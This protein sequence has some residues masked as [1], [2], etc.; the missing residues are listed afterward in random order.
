MVKL[1]V[2]MDP[3][4]SINIEK[5]T[6]F[7]MLLEAQKR[8][9][10]IYYM[11]IKDIFMYEGVAY[12]N[13]HL[14]NVEK[15][16]KHWYFFYKKQNI[17]LSDLDVILMRKDPPFDMQYIYSTYILEQAERSGSIIVNKPQSLRDCNEK[18]YISL[19]N[20]F[21]PSTLVTCNQNELKNFW[22]K[23]I[24]IV[25]KPLDN[26]GGKS[27]F[28]LRKD[29]SNFSVVIESLTKNG[30]F[31]CI[32][33]KYVPDIKYGD[34]RILLVDGE[35]VPYCLARIPRE[36][37]HRANLSI[38]GYGEVRA[39]S[40]SDLEISR[41]IG[42]NLKKKGLM[43]VG[44]DIIGDKVTEINVTSPTGICQIEAAVPISIT[45]MLM[46]SIEKLLH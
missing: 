36:G 6:T 41:I 16:H 26:M 31:F 19:F 37:D 11:E 8:R 45:S 35:P 2:L 22:Q 46:D 42:L 25:V 9:Y 38:G 7:A 44:L 27:V 15:N 4:A 10:T 28:F 13:T 24:D 18:L 3:I 32:A 5:D 43:F 23:H 14:L 30:S 12:A 17:K 20:E 1:G 40:A 29:D 33:Q 21:T 34:K 39:L